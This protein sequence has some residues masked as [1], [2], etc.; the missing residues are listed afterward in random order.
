MI[1][2]Q[3]E[4]QDV[5]DICCAI[6]GKQINSLNVEDASV[7]DTEVVCKACERDQ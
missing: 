1:A 2:V 7:Y 3:I 4:F 6:C 5:T